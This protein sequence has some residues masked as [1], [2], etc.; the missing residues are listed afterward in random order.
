MSFNPS[1]LT[2]IAADDVLITMGHAKS[3][4]KLAQACS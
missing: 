3:Q 2:A 4:A 1:H